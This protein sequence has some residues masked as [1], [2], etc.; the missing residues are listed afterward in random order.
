MSQKVIDAIKSKFA[1]AV[2]HTESQF[3]DEIALIKRDALK[4]IALFLRDDPAMA[5]DQAMFVTCLDRSEQRV[6]GIADDEPV[7]PRF[8]V[9][10]QLRSLAHR[11][12]VRLAVR[13][14]EADPRVASLASVWPALNWQERETYDMYGIKFE[15]H[16]DLR[17]IYL[18]EEFVGFPLR[19]DYPKDKRQPLI[20]RADLQ[21]ETL[22]N[23]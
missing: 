13:V 11:H 23:K 4:D 6:P 14:T 7:D 16:P 21:T 17:R 10:Y 22:E 1:H 3:G 9:S 20:R 19:K 12:R 5:F 2:E 15:G 18:Y 8:E